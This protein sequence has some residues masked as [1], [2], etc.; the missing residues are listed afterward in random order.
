ML[1]D[2]TL[3]TQHKSTENCDK[4]KFHRH[5]ASLILELGWK[6][7]DQPFYCNDPNLYLPVL[8]KWKVICANYFL[9][10]F[11]SSFHCK[12]CSPFSLHCK[13]VRHI[14]YPVQCS[15]VL[16]CPQLDEF[17]MLL[18]TTFDLPTHFGE[19]FRIIL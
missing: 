12:Y 7:T 6:I 3:S 18:Q 11:Y 13:Y 9:G 5:T 15:H 8:L 1:Q 2:H 16:M 10:S 19:K 14:F 17:L 4:H